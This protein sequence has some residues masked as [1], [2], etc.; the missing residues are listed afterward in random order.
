MTQR[1]RQTYRNFR[2]KHWN[3]PMNIYNIYMKTWFLQ[4]LNLFCRWTN[5]PCISDNTADFLSKELNH[6]KPKNYLEI[7]CAAGY[8]IIYI[9]NIIWLR[10]GCSTWFEISYPNF[11]MAKNHIQ[12][13]WLD[14]INLTLQ[15][16]NLFDTAKR[17]E[18]D[19]KFDFVMIDAKKADYH[20]FLIKI[21]P[22]VIDGGVII[23]DDVIKYADKMPEFYSYLTD[24]NINYEIIWLDEDD[25]II[26]I[27]KK[28]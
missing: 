11:I 21:W 26:K 3:K 10:G 2:L 13:S 24:N 19:T 8:S 22:F 27:I 18:D 4:N 20:K 1:Q 7:G 6:Y 16:F 14:N 15:N 5:V 25:W 17:S 28:V 23:C 9:S 12:A